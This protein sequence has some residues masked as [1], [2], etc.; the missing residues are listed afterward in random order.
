MSEYYNSRTVQVPVSMSDGDRMSLYYR[1][2]GG[3]WTL[4]TDPTAPTGLFTRSPITFQAPGDGK[5]EVYSVASNETYTENKQPAAEATFTVDT[6]PPTLAITSPVPGSVLGSGKAT[7]AWSASD[8]GSGV[9]SS[10][11]S[12]DGHGPVDAIGSYTFTGLA[13]GTHTAEVTVR[14]KANNIVK[15]SVTFLVNLTGPSMTVSPTGSEVPRT[16]T[17]SVTFHEEMDKASIVISVSGVE[18]SLA[19]SGDQV[20]FTPNLLLAYDTTYQVTVAGRDAEGDAF[21]THWSF[22][23]VS[24]GGVVSGTVK[25]ANG[26]PIAN[27]VVELSNGMTTTTNATGYFEFVGV[28]AGHYNMVVSKNGYVMLNKD[29]KVTGLNEDIGSLSARGTYIAGDDYLPLALI[30]VVALSGLISVLLI[31]RKRR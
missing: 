29:V 18:G 24:Q 28:P 23:T 26:N 5:Y 11:V 14:D 27:A 6:V 22:T 20:T 1:P 13:E 16:S 10:T 17:I 30:C 8:L 31:G 19:W 3:E 15:A 25:D 2:V 4:Y 9:L 12:V 21:T 7:I